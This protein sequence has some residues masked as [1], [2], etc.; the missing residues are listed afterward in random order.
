[1]YFSIEYLVFLMSYDNL[2]INIQSVS[3]CH[4]KSIHKVHMK[5]KQI[6]EK[7]WKTQK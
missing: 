4:A 3:K 7:T 5:F 2:S 6:T 1:M